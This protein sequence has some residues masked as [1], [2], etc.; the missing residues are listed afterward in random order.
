MSMFGPP[1]P[2]YEIMFTK[3][4][5]NDG[6]MDAH[7]FQRLCFGLGY[8]LTDEEQALALKVLDADGSGMLELAEFKDWWKREDRWESIQL[9]GFELEKRKQAAETFNQ[10]DPDRTGSVD[11]ANFPA[12]YNDL[13]AKNLTHHSQEKAMENLDASGDGRIQF[14]E[15]IE[16]LKSQGTFTYGK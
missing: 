1:K 8:A 12:L 4:A 7:E 14:K 15:Y 5:G 10:F 16:Y 3:Y 11:K 2:V 6:R 13:K 9:Q